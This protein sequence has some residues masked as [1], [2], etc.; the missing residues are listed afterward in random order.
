MGDN[1]AE[2]TRILKKTGALL[3]GHFEL[4]SGLHSAAYVQCAQVLQYPEPAEKLGRLLSERF[5]DR[6]I[7]VV[8]SPA[9][10]G[11]VIGH[12]VARVLGTRAIFAERQAL[13]DGSRK[14]TLRRGFKINSGEKVLVVEDVI[15]TGGSTKEIMDIVREAG[16]DIVGVGSLI[17]RSSGKTDFGVYT[18]T[19]LSLDIKTCDPE[20][21]PLC[22]QG[23]PLVKPGSQRFRRQVPHLKIPPISLQSDKEG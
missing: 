15:T 20:N 17:D 6:G 8:V 9:L 18:N 11:V 21:C 2:L 19:L 13:R 7:E 5:R 14:M 23:I 16:G 4:S 3:E 1:T 10:G 12:E 22:R